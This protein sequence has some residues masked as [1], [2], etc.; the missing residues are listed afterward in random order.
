M[1]HEDQTIDR[2][3][4]N[5]PI[6]RARELFELG[7]PHGGYDVLCDIQDEAL[8]DSETYVRV[9]L[10]KQLC[11]LGMDCLEGGINALER[12]YAAQCCFYEVVS[13]IPTISET[14]Q[15]QAEFWKR[16]GDEN[17]AARLLRSIQAVFPTDE[18]EK[19]I[20]KFQASPVYDDVILNTSHD[21]NKN[22]RILF[23]TNGKRPDF[24]LDVLFDGLCAI[25]GP[26]NVT[27]YPWKPS[28]HGGRFGPEEEMF[29]QYPCFFNHPG[30]KFSIQELNERLKSGHF[31][32]ILYG[33]LDHSV[34]RDEAR[35]V[36]AAGEDLPLYVIDQKDDPINNLPQV[37]EFLGRDSAN[38]YFKREYLHCVDF[39][40]NTFPMPFAYPQNRIPDDL[41]EQ[42]SHALLWAGHRRFGLRRLYLEKL[43]ELTGENLNAGCSQDDYSRLMRISNIGLSLF[44]V[45]FDTIRYWELPAHGCMLLAERP[46][47]R[48]PN[49]F[50]D[51]KTAIFFNDLPEL[52]EKLEYY[53]NHPQETQSIAIAGHNHL[54]KHHTGKVRA[55]QLLEYAQS[56][57]ERNV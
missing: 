49:D 16:I 46:P 29:E 42:R 25:I 20:E 11:L 47:I 51:G 12:F 31:D 19:R 26:E 2:T 6:V 40:P 24:G 4:E 5:D 21:V 22:V 56:T 52:I 32:L 45:G 39:G 34:S 18:A 8:S 10:E 1:A 7:Q 53:L 36:M 43:E 35:A 9:E 44:G 38:A 23:I 50:K 14:Y 37:L 54:K 27:E 30:N 13:A 15:C 55:N 41:S 28:L 3:S 48:I 57:I 17:M 33:D